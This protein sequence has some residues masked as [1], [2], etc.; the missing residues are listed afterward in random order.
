MKWLTASPYLQNQSS[1]LATLAVEHN[2]C[3][4]FEPFNTCYSDTGLFGFHFVSDPLSVDD[5]MFCAQGEWMR[6]CTSTTESEVTRAKNYLRNAMV[7]QLDGTTRVCEN[8]GSHL[9]HYGRRIPLEEW[10][11][12][13]SAVDAKMVRDVCSKYIYDKCPAIAAVGPI[14]QLLD[15]NRLRS[16]MYWVRL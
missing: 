10:D 4:S 1:K 11:A 13:I 9:L 6:L 8:I 7:A 12:R 2:L 14:E 3:H 16:A 5:M 15:Y